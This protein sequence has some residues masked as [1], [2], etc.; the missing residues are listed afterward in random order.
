MS[1]T[2]MAS[3]GLL[4]IAQR[5]GS[6]ICTSVDLNNQIPD[7]SSI[8]ENIEDVVSVVLV[9]DVYHT[10]LFARSDIGKAV[11]FNS[12]VLMDK[13]GKCVE[14]LDIFS[15]KRR[16]NLMYLKVYENSDIDYKEYFRI[17]NLPTPGFY[18]E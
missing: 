7:C 17:H 13:D 2:K 12:S 11:V 16:G 8:S 1:R 6:M 9:T 4:I 18:I 5:S 10:D 15:G 14:R 3:T